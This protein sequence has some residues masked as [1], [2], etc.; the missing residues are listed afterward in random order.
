MKYHV[1]FPQPEAVKQSL[2]TLG[3][4]LRETRQAAAIS[5]YPNRNTLSHLFVDPYNHILCKFPD[6]LRYYFLF[7]RR[8]LPRTQED[9]DHAPRRVG[10]DQPL[11]SASLHTSLKRLRLVKSPGKLIKF[12]I[13]LEHIIVVCLYQQKPVRQ[14]AQSNQLKNFIHMAAVQVSIYNTVSKLLAIQI[15]LPV[16]STAFK[17]PEKCW[18]IFNKYFVRIHLQHSL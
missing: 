6:F 10:C 3:I 7:R 12:R 15:I 5:A 17:P 1:V 9:T 4:S 2:L 18:N 16:F 8:F 13:K 11:N 14:T